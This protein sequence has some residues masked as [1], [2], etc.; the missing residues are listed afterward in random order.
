MDGGSWFV[1][2]LMFRDMF[3]SL[4][5]LEWNVLRLSVNLC[6][7]ITRQWNYIRKPFSRIRDAR[8]ST[9]LKL[10]L[11]C[12]SE[13][14]PDSKHIASFIVPFRRLRTVAYA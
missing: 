2:C 12:L 13:P 4:E 11:E 6:E 1:G 8:G 14:G 3:S 10:S 5:D 7:I 9:Y